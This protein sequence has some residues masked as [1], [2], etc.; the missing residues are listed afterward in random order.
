VLSCDRWADIAVDTDVMEARQVTM[1]RRHRGNDD[2][3]RKKGPEGPIAVQNHQ[4]RLM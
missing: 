3:V 4:R 1:D 2:T